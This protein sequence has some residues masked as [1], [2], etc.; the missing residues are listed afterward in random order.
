MTSGANLKTNRNSPRRGRSFVVACAA[1]LL[2]SAC[3]ATGG[4][5]NMA[6]A[7]ADTATSFDYATWDSY[8]GGADSSQYS[9]AAQIDTGNVGQLEVAWTYDLGPGQAPQFNPV[10]I[11]NTLYLMN[12][13]ALVALDAATG[14]E[15]WTKDYGGR[16][17]VRGMNYWQSA[18]GT[19]RRLLFLND[20]ML[21][22][23]NADNGEPIAGFGTD[24]KVDIRTGLE[25]NKMPERP[26]M[27]NNPGR[28]YKNTIIVSLPA[29]AYDFASA[30]A[31]IHAYD[32][33][34]GALKWVFHTVPEKG[35]FG[36]ETWPEKDHEK[37][38]GV[39]NWSESTVD[40]K[41]G[42]AFIPTG[43]ARYDF[44]GGN[45][46][47]N[48]LF[49]NSIVA[50]DAETGK[51]VWHFQ[52]LHHDLWDW[53][54]PQAPKLM[55]IHKDGKDIPVL[56]QAT[57]FGYIYVLDRRTGKPVWPI[58]EKPVPAS[59]VPG[60][61]ASPTQ[62]V[63][64]WPEPFARQGKFTPDMINPYISE[65]DQAKLREMLKTARNEGMYTPPSLGTGSISFPGHNGG[66][67]W[68]SS[69]VDPVKKRFFV[70]SKQMP[71]LDTL[72]LD[73]RPEA[74]AAMPNGGGDVKPYK[75]GVNFLLQSNGL[76]AV[77]P[78]WSKITAYDMETGKKIWD[79]PNGEV[80]M[81]A[82]KGIHDTGSTA[83]RGGP[84]AT[85]GGLVFVGTSSD[86]KVR[87]R[88]AATGKVLW[89]HQLDAASEGVPIV[90][91]EGGKEYVVFPVGGDGLFPPK[92]GQ[93]KPGPNRYVA[94]A[95]PGK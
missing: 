70:V 43:T 88:D 58:E 84:V 72:V 50:L 71:T 7:S 26:L 47:G 56:I 57:K 60:E 21:R 46:E 4:T 61:K 5:S 83:P 22:A 31:D 3:T 11:G 14:A 87:A 64:T 2:A 92:L 81:L 74:Q 75:S 73:E 86:R 48:N 63:P 17:G 32:V 37:F 82:E 9:S 39:H 40:E 25:P 67:N 59:D 41:L 1:A 68:G 8:L 52:V 33:R 18:D 20:G 55:T 16:V 65:E 42:L 28:I 38:G 94:F 10:K 69:A 24:G 91:T 15:K 85:A 27:T 79:L 95:L 30:P 12:G 45:R 77:N 34:T 76:P 49:A 62:P 36:Y 90:Y 66:A 29:A 13:G 78:P 53:D 80:M 54:I 44:Y 6:S 19:D 23:V 35:E 93:P 89:E 51:R